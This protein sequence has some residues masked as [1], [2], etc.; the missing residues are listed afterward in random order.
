MTAVQLD[1]RARLFALRRQWLPTR[2]VLAVLERNVMVYRRAPLV[3]FSGFFEPVLY[4]LSLSVGVSRLVGDI[5]LDGKSVS[6]VSFVAPA[7]LATSAMNGAF[8]ESTYQ[9]FQKLLDGKTYQGM[10]AT[11][12]TVGDMAAGEVLWAVF[13]GLVYSTGFLLMA[14]V[15]GAVESWWAILA[16]PGALLICGAFAAAGQVLTSTFMK[17]PNDMDLVGLVTQ[18]LFLC[19]ATFF[20]LSTY[21]AWAERVVAV[22]PL[23]QGVA[24]ERA[25]TTGA[26]GASTF[27]NAVYLVVMMVGC[28]AFSSVR[29]HRRLLH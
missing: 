26:V 19:S 22:T 20:P 14:L 1:R 24:M 17:T 4:M 21:P 13:R 23:Y 3:V 8:F 10:L 16:L 28:L 2:R 6:Y 15:L 29:F 5:E 18:P 9:L 11:P 12:V 27:V 7:L 25:L